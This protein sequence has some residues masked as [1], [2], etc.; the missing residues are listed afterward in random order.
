[1]RRLVAALLLIAAIPAQAQVR[2]VHEIA[3]DRPAAAP[4]GEAGATDVYTFVGQPGSQVSFTLKIKGDAEIALFGPHG[5]PMLNVAGSGTVKLDAVL[6]WLDVHSVAVLRR[7]PSQPYTLA[8]TATEP[9][10]AEARH[11]LGMGYTLTTEGGTPY[12]HCWL[13]P[14]VAAAYRGKDYRAE[15]V[16]SADRE[17]IILMMK[18]DDGR[19]AIRIVKYQIDGEEMINTTR[20]FGEDTRE[21]RN[22]FDLSGFQ[23]DET[24]RDYV[25]YT[26]P[27]S[28]IAK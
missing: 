4:A 17:S 14:G 26:C 20:R 22:E 9:T 19:Q 28:M 8:M 24:K 5:E 7:D 18:Y 1:V 3:P 21:S 6:S 10:L 16:L 13:K 25:G 27:T 11:A 2:G 23:A 12:S 15:S